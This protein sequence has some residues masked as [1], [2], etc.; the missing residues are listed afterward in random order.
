M[1]WILYLLGT[2][3]LLTVLLAA[4]V[5]ILVDPNDYKEEIAATVSEQTGREFAIEGDLSLKLLPCCGIRLGPLALGNP[6]GFPAGNFARIED[7]TVSVRLWPLLM[8]QELQAGKIELDGL[9]VRLIER[10]DGSNNWDFSTP[11]EAAADTNAETDS[12]TGLGQLDIE[13]V[14]VSNSR[15]SYLEE[16]TGE[17]LTLGG[18]TLNT[19]RIRLDEPIDLKAAFTVEGLAPD[20]TA[21][22]ELDTRV[23][24]SADLATA[25]LTD[26]TGRVGLKAPDLPNGAAEI[27]LALAAA[28]NLG[29]DESALEGLKAT[30]SAGDLNLDVTAGGALAADGPR[31]S[32]TLAAPPFPLRK[33]LESAGGEPLVTADPQALQRLEMRGDWTFAGDTAALENL[34]LKLDASTIS[35]WLRVNSIEKEAAEFDLQIDTLN[36][37]GYLAPDS[38]TAAPGGA[39]AGAAS[40]DE[41]LDLPM[42]ELRS[43]DLK[44]RFGIG[45]LQ[46]SDAQL[47]DVTVNLLA[48]KGSIRLHPLTASLYGGG[49]EGDLRLNVK[50]EQPELSLNEKLTGVKLSKLLTDTRGSANLTGVGNIRIQGTARGNS[51]NALLANLSGDTA[52]ELK[53]GSY[54]GVDIWYEIRRAYAQLRGK[55]MP[56]VPANPRTEISQFSGSARFSEGKLSND[57]FIAQIPFI[58]MSGRGNVDLLRS[59]MDYRLEA[60]VV[61]TPT[62]ADSEP[63]D[64]L[65]G[66]ALPITLQ[67]DLNGPKV[68][69]DLAS[70]AVS[71]GERKLR[72]R[73]MKNSASPTMPTKARPPTER[74]RRNRMIRNPPIRK[75]S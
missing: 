44:G 42:E 40:G 19:G 12:G 11:D 35:G 47:T 25:D 41:P 50:G 36:L 72:E 31:L 3:V 37:D 34:R 69:V 7:A 39:S 70:L 30:I 71:V 62:F 43:L 63:L 1:R 58:R 27:G 67:G 32:G 52:L 18:L 29:G 51:I 24:L 26:L 57:D 17:P 45:K 38:D 23:N 13:G 48:R 56:A 14:S 59:L 10:A 74:S 21:A 6:A 66:L 53:D 2:L 22:L 60:T 73:L 16:A 8:N 75:T 55:K 33:L 9:D 15:L 68:S 49:Y 20:T 65:K 4:A 61:G 5:V 64:E 46:V 54:E 28:R